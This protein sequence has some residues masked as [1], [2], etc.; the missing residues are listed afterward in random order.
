M[1][2]IN[3]DEKKYLLSLKPDDIT[4]ELLQD[5]FSDTAEVIG[6]KV[7]VKKSKFVPNDTFILEPN[8]YFNKSK[9][10]TTVGIFIFNK[11]L[12]E[13]DFKDTVG[14]INTTIR[15]SDAGDIENTIAKL[16]LD[17]KIT[18]DKLVNYVN[19]FQWLGMRIHPMIC[20]SFTPKTF[21]PIPEVIAL[22]DKLF[23]ENKEAIEA[24]DAITMEKIEEK[25]IKKAKEEIG[26][27]PGLALYDSGARGSFENNYKTMCITQGAIFNPGS[28]KNEISKNCFLEGIEK[29]S[30]PLSGNSVVAGAYPKAV[31][32]GVSGYFTKQILAAL[33]ATTINDEVEDCKTK[34]TI[35]VKITPEQASMFDYKYIV[36]NGKLVLLTSENI[37]KYIG[38]TV[39]MRSAVCCPEVKICKCCIG[40]LYEKMDIK[41]IGLTA[42]KPSSALT[43]LSMK[44]FH[45]ST[46]HITQIDFS[47]ITI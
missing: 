15:N 43:Q 32:T 12:I 34:A 25:L 33:Q 28:G 2:K 36:E 47:D 39:N 8:E 17:D 14:Y 22:R 30:I 13:E 42:S 1:R 19:K 10:E 11:F 31:G 23:E 26:D 5:L 29:T 38:K 24:G 44:K 16:L 46:I 18:R 3:D 27:D 9:I 35:P 4:F 40:R 20:P 45:D 37:K 21:K 41:N 6:D 7:N